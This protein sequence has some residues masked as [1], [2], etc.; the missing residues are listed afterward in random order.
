ME[1]MKFEIEE[2]G[3][4]PQF[5]QPIAVVGSP[6]LSS[7]GKIALDYLIEK[8]EPR[9]FIEIYSSNFPLVHMGPSYFA[10]EGHGG[11][12]IKDGVVDLPRI[13]IYHHDAPELILV[14]GYHA[15]F[16]AQFEVAT[17]VAEILTEC[18][19]KRMYVLASHGTGEEEI[20]YAASTPSLSK[21]MNGLGIARREAGGFF[22]FSGLVVGMAALQNIE[23]ICLFARTLVDRDDLE[24]PDPK[25]AKVLLDRLKV[26]L[27]LEF[28]TKDLD[29]KRPRTEIKIEPSE[30]KDTPGYL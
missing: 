10:T 22:G 17:K 12:S 16:K 18:K 3:E 24:R 23:G 2:I 13:K 4:R 6:G 8:L 11:V 29:E 25:A 19:V 7:V 14:K 5:N 28:D 20:Y 1:K 9:P 30:E 27:E 26:L 21:D 15:D